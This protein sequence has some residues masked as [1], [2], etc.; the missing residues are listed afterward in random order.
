MTGNLEEN[1]A[2]FFILEGVEELVRTL[3][4]FHSNP[5]WKR[6][7]MSI[8]NGSYWLV[9]GKLKSNTVWQGI[10]KYDIILFIYL[11]MYLSTYLFIDW[12]IKEVKYFNDFKNHSF[13]V[14]WLKW[15]QS[16]EVKQNQTFFHGTYWSLASY[17]FIKKKYSDDL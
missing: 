6:S 13:S 1:A 3:T 5:S 12:L 7:D 8:T 9:L 17:F 4:P 14:S 15:T 16:V 11:F 2:M 10:F